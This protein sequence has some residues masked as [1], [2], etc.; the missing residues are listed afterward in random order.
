MP[1][2]I[3][4]WRSFQALSDA[5]AAAVSRFCLFSFA[6][7][8]V[9]CSPGSSNSALIEQE[10]PDAWRWVVFNSDGLVVDGGSESTEAKA[11]KAVEAALHV[12]EVSA[13]TVVS[14]R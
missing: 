1:L 8:E 6:T 7:L 2:S 13:A 11:K 3:S 4:T 5:E 10:H 12:L 9:V 14:S